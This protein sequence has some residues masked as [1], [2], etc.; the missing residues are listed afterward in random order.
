MIPLKG[1]DALQKKV[2][3]SVRIVK[4]FWLNVLSARFSRLF[5]IRAERPLVLS[6]NRKI[7]QRCSY[8]Y[9]DAAP[10]TPRSYASFET[11]SRKLAA[12]HI[13]CHE[14]H[15]SWICWPIVWKLHF[16]LL[17]LDK[18]IMAPFVIPI[19]TVFSQGFQDRISCLTPSHF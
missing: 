19:A 14:C 15:F 8:A 4:P 3:C 1:C 5:G 13:T 9:K 11:R 16:H 18:F 6:R 7:N 2:K 10:D 12:I 17:I